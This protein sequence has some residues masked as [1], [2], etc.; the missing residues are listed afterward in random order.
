[1]GK[2]TLICGRLLLAHR[3]GAYPGFYD[4][5]LRGVNMQEAQIMGA[6]M[7]APELMPAGAVRAYGWESDGRE[8]AT[9]VHYTGRECAA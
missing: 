7:D 9:L 6:G 4:H 1:M 8:F 5:E 3:T 2:V